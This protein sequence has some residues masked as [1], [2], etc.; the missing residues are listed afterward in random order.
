MATRSMKQQIGDVQ[1]YSSTFDMNTGVLVRVVEEPPEAAD[2]WRRQ[3]LAEYLDATTGRRSGQIN[4]LWRQQFRYRRRAFSPSPETLDISITDWC[5]YGCAYCYQSSAPNLKHGPADHVEQVL[6]AF[7]HVPYQVA[8][9]GGEPTAHPQLPAILRRARELGCV[10]NFTTAGHIWREDVIKAANDVCGGVSLSFHSERGPDAFWETYRLWRAA[11]K[12]QLNV[13]VV[14]DKHVV[15]RLSQL[16][17]Y[18]E[19]LGKLSI[20]LLAYYSEAGHASAIGDT[21]IMPWRTY[22][23]D[24][25]NILKKMLARGHRVAF[26]E[27]MLPYFLSRPEIGIDTSQAMASEGRFSAYV[28]LAGRLY[29]SSFDAPPP[30]KRGEGQIAP[31]ATLSKKQRNQHLQSSW[32]TMTWA[33]SGS[34]SETSA[35]YSECDGCSS[36]LRCATPDKHHYFICAHAEHNKRLPM[37]MNVGTAGSTP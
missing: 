23:Y 31:L 16:L 35:Y 8:I 2:R 21:G 9:G 24:L 28:D 15:E 36:Q 5:N 13:H 1:F 19:V 6:T 29:K 34:W 32:N 3:S 30:D 33:E 14:A 37:I 11:L 12:T 10:P 27:G 17:S 7:D 25:P 26:S 18:E 22:H 20:V 4:E